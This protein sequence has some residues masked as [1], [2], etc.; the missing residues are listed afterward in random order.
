MKNLKYSRHSHYPTSQDC[1]VATCLCAG[2]FLALF[3]FASC[4]EIYP[5]DI[6]NKDPF[7]KF[8]G[9]TLQKTIINEYGNKI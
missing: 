8:K 7:Y 4:R 6:E 5:R 2:V 9:K 3:I 1:G